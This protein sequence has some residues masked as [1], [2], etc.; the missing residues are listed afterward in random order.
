MSLRCLPD[1]SKMSPRCP[2]CLSD[3]MRCL[4]DVSQM[5]SRCLSGVPDVS[6]MRCLPDA[7]QMSSRSLPDVSQVSSRCLSDVSQMSPR[8]LP[9][10]SQ[11]SARCFQ[12]VSRLSR[13]CLPGTSQ[14][15]PR[16][17]QTWMYINPKSIHKSYD[18]NSTQPRPGPGLGLGRPIALDSRNSR[19]HS[20]NSGPEIR[21]IK[22]H[23]L[24][25]SSLECSP[26][27]PRSADRSVS[28][29]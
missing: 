15:S 18:I 7:S 21:E 11:M 16:R 13:R 9:D 17:L 20:R 28:S 14:M 3:E 5:S 27:V 6:Q 12:D 23:K 10:V 1:V 25:K 22:N 4:P 8:Y 19:P 24:L 29:S 2:R 26:G